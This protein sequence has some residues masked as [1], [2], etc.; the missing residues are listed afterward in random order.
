MSEGLLHKLFGKS[1]R[2]D[3]DLS[4]AVAELTRLAEKRPHWAEPI[5]LLRY[6]SG[7]IF[8]PPIPIQCPSLVA[9]DQLAKLASGVPLARGETFHVDR[10]V[11][12][13]RWRQIT[14]SISECQRGDAAERLAGAAKKGGLDPAFLLDKVLAG[15]QEAVYAAALACDCDPGL[16]S[17]ALRL[18]V[19]TTLARLGDEWNAHRGQARWEHGYCPVCGNRPLLGE[20]RGLEQILFLRCGWCAAQ[21]E[22]PRLQC[23]FCLTRDHQR[24]GYLN[25]DGEGEK[26]RAATCDNCRTY[27]KLVNTLTALSPIDLLVAD[28]STLHL[29]L[30]ARGQNYGNG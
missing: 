24:L 23:P 19:F 28:A 13:T 18:T 4:H 20:L 11:L 16:T 6:L 21:W 1:Q 12:Q 10:D 17:T 14:A 27:V 7:L 30:V 29:D 25:V 22:F 26:E 8:A 15:E 5:L 2:H 3:G 9:S